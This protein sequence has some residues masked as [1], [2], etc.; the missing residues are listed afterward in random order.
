MDKMRGVKRGGYPRNIGLRIDLQTKF[1]YV[2]SMVYTQTLEI[3]TSMTV[4]FEIF[5]S[6]KVQGRSYMKSLVDLNARGEK[7]AFGI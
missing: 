7:S 4:R 6:G 5:P 3:F 1:V 2:S